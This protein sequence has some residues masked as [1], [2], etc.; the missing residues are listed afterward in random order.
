M[1]MRAARDKH[2]ELSAHG[3]RREIAM[4]TIHQLEKE[5]EIAMIEDLII[6]SNLAT[7]TPE[8]LTS[9][10]TSL[11]KAAQYLNEVEKGLIVDERV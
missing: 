10:A 3:T 11:N 5:T 2:R 4:K 9:L 1:P 6:L 7:C 8:K